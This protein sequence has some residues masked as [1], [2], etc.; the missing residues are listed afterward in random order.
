MDSDEGFVFALQGSWGSGKTTVLNFVQRYLEP[1][2]QQ[3]QIVIVRFNPWWFSGQDQ[4]L[5]QFFRAFYAA[6]G[7]KDTPTSLKAIADPLKAFATAL[8]PLRYLPLVGSWADPLRAVTESFATRLDEASE[9]AQR[10]LEH[11]RAEIDDLL[12]KQESRILVIIDDID[13]LRSEEIQLIF[14][15]I[16]AVGNFP[17]TIYLLAFDK[18]VVIRALEGFGHSSGRSY[19][20]KIIQVA[21]DLPL[22]E[23][24]TLHHILFEELVSILRH[25]PETLWD[26]TEL[27][28]LLLEG[29]GP[30]IHTPRDVKRLV[31][32]VRIAYPLVQGEVNAVDFI[33]VQTLRSFVPHVYDYLSTGRDIFAGAGELV[34]SEPA[35][36]REIWKVA[37]DKV[38]EMSSEKRD[39][40]GG[41]MKR[42]FPRWQSMYDE[43]HYDRDW[44]ETW[45]RERRVC[46]PRFFDVYFMLSLPSTDVSDIEVER[47]VNLAWNRDALRAELRRLAEE[48]PLPGVPRIWAFL[49]RVI[50]VSLSVKQVEALLAAI[51]IEADQLWLLAESD[52]QGFAGIDPPHRL[53]RVS[54]RLLGRIEDEI[55]RFRILKKLLAG[56]AS[57]SFAVYFVGRIED[58]YREGVLTPF[59]RDEG[60]V[61]LKQLTELEQLALE[62]I[63]VA[64]EEDQLAKA[65]HWIHV[66]RRLAEWGS[67]DDAKSY[68]TRLVKRDEGLADYLVGCLL[69]TRIVSARSRVVKPGWT[70]HPVEVQSYLDADITQ[71]VRRCE[72]ILAASPSWL[73]DRRRLALQTFIRDFGGRESLLL[74]DR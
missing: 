20:E 61:S 22:P 4:L 41:L 42:L 47:L 43:S 40:V 18:D 17:R 39:A 74:S 70:F 2:R 24:T 19:L 52:G 60:G 56:D 73:T 33:G 49:E 13:R 26:S 8:T 7:R 3:K 32:G 27:Y 25:T 44:L 69:R 72:S 48:K 46:S 67:V 54:A 55:S 57:V 16:K 23:R 50:D 63:R 6:L 31:N 68:V 71:L 36:T 1:A 38:L 30:F 5:M 35:S 66:V 15:V 37:F 62:K 65:P 9:E 34:A 29:I 59:P 58:E 11:A 53:F 12:R 45:R 21:F 64:I 51:F 10:D 28:D 14:Q